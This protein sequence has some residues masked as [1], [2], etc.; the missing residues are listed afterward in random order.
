V[1]AVH[2]FRLAQLP[3]DPYHSDEPLTIIANEVEPEDPPG[4][5]MAAPK[6][7]VAEG[8]DGE[9]GAAA[10]ASS[11]VNPKPTEDPAAKGGEP[12]TENAD[13]PATET[14][15]ADG[16]PGSDAPPIAD[17]PA[18]PIVPTAD[19]EVAPVGE[20]EAKAAEEAEQVA[21]PSVPRFPVDL[22]EWQPVGK[23]L[24]VDLFRVPTGKK[25][26]GKW[27]MRILESSH[28]LMT[29]PYPLA[30]APKVSTRSFGPCTAPHRALSL[31]VCDVE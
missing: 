7:P 13:V 4:F 22:E 2:R 21:E 20:E 16:V 23:V 11:E 8:E 24:L 29:L 6:P 12:A 10:V 18:D 9:A 27:Y 14:A 1:R 17:T 15:P 3:S 31:Y 30:D 28:E 5:E 19:G 26:V 25:Q